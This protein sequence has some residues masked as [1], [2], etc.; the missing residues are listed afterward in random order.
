MKNG[1]LKGSEIESP[2]INVSNFEHDELQNKDSKEKIE[3]DMFNYYAWYHVSRLKT[4]EDNR[5]NVKITRRSKRK[6]RGLI[7]A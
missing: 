1:F 7:D 2:K 4:E 6:K 3:Y 5:R